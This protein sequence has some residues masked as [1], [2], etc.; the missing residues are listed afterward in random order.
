MAILHLGSDR[1]T[2][3]FHLALA[4]DHVSREI[5][6]SRLSPVTFR[7]WE[8]GHADG[9]LLDLG[10]LL[11]VQREVPSILFEIDSDIS[12]HFGFGP[13]TQQTSVT[14]TYPLRATWR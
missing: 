5:R 1:I 6:T 9:R 10:P 8:Q 7:V 3:G 11:S 13:V 12:G 14:S 4:L 2:I